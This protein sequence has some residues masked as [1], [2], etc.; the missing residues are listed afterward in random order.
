MMEC[1]EIQHKIAAFLKNELDE[2]DTE[3]FVEH[4][5]RCDSCMEE[6]AIQYLV[7]EGM[8]RLEDGS[9]FDLN[10]E[11]KEKLE[12]TLRRIRR[13]KFFNR[14]MLSLEI[15]SVFVTAVLSAFVLY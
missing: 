8:R 12:Y 6:L 3:D 5:R 13:K 4:I 11:L 7:T 10:R 1:V 14:M 2:R 9:T 15:A